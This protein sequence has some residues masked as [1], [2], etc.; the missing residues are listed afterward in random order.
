MR[1][2]GAFVLGAIIGTVVMWPWGWEIEM[3]VEEKAPVPRLPRGRARITGVSRSRTSLHSRGRGRAT[4]A[5]ELGAEGQRRR[6]R[7]VRLGREG[8]AAAVSLHDTVGREEVTGHGPIQVREVR[9]DVFHSGELLRGAHEGVQVVRDGVR[10]G[11]WGE[12]TLAPAVS[13]PRSL[14]SFCC[15]HRLSG[16]EQSPPGGLLTLIRLRLYGAF[17]VSTPRTSRRRDGHATRYQ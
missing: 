14:S 2:N 9:E 4:S 15:W 3:Y 6:R 13:R 8:A 12:I 10:D 11:G 7:I 1:T 16:V 17:S 5:E